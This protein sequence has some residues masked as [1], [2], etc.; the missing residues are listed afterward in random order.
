MDELT[1]LKLAHTEVQSN[2]SIEDQGIDILLKLVSGELTSA[3]LHLNGRECMRTARIAT[4]GDSRLAYWM[5][6]PFGS[7]GSGTYLDPA[8]GINEDRFTSLW[9]DSFSRITNLRERKKDLQLHFT[10]M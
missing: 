5:V 1:I 9:L 4:A 8:S 6:D 7:R 10:T 2:Q 3:S